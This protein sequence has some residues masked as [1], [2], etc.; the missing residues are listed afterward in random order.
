[1]D[2]VGRSCTDPQLA[3]QLIKVAYNRYWAHQYFLH[4]MHFLIKCIV[5]ALYEVKV[6]IQFC[7]TFG[8]L[9]LND[10]PTK[11]IQIN[12]LLT[13]KLTNQKMAFKFSWSRTLGVLLP[14]REECPSSLRVVFMQTTNKHKLNLGVCSLILFILNVFNMHISLVCKIFECFNLECNVHHKPRLTQQN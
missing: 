6:Q 7:H 8:V 13:A 4:K 12:S 3:I 10:L 1:M 2:M 11:S 5:V 14:L 9:E